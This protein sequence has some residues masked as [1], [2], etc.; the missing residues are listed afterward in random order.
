[1]NSF[2]DQVLELWVLTIKKQQNINIQNTCNIIFYSL[3]PL[4]TDVSGTDGECDTEHMLERNGVL[5]PHKSWFFI[6]HSTIE[7]NYFCSCMRYPSL[8][9]LKV[10]H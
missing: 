10:T 4:E 1:M 5:Y 8:Q 2:S 9:F 6:F 3:F 7:G